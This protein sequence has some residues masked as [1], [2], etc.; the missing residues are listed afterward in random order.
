[1]VVTAPRK[2]HLGDGLMSKKLI[3]GFIQRKRSDIG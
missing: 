1:M 3:P 2:V